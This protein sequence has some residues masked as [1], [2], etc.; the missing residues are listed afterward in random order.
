[1]KPGKLQLG[2]EAVPV[3]YE[4]NTVLVGNRRERNGRLI[5]MRIPLGQLRAAL[6]AMTAANLVT[7]EG[8][9]LPIE[10][11]RNTNG[12]EIEFIY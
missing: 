8:Q 4:L 2:D 11:T 10:F 3:Q 1:V 9:M 5:L 6:T 7:D 12:Q